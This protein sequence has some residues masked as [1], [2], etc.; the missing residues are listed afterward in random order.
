MIA[1][2]PWRSL[3]D[4]PPPEGVDRVMGTDGLFSREMWRNALGVWM[5]FV[6]SLGLRQWHPTHW[7]P[8]P[9]AR[10]TR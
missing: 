6:F 4:D 10:V 7:Q 3:A 2:I 8:L 9:D 1:P 5:C